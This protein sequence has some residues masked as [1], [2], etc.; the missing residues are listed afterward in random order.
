MFDQHNPVTK[1]KT[2]KIF[3]CFRRFLNIILEIILLIAFTFIVFMLF[4]F[5]AK[6][7]WLIF[8]S[9]PIGQ[10]YMVIF[11]ESCRTTNDVLNR[12]NIGLA[13]NLTLT[14]CAICLILGAILKFLHIT[15]YLY[16]GRGFLGR[17][18][19]FG[20]PAVYIVAVYLQYRGDFTR[21]DTAFTVAI[22]PALC[23][24]ARCFKYTE[25]FVPEIADII[26]RFQK[27]TD[28][29]DYTEQKE[30][31]L[32]GT[33][34]LRQKA[35]T[36]QSVNESVYRPLKLKDIWEDYRVYIIAIPIIIVITTIL[37]AIS[38]KLIFNKVDY[39]SAKEAPQIESPV[40]RPEASAPPAEL[41]GSAQD[42][43]GKALVLIDSTDRNDILK[44]IEYLN[45]AIRQK[46]DYVDAYRQRGAFYAKLDQYS[47]AIDDYDEVIRLKPRDGNLY[48]MRGNAYFALGKISLA[49]SDAKKA[50][51]LGN[52]KLFKIAKGDGDCL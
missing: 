24:F 17:T 40:V 3:S 45:E 27:Q 12:D 34:E 26:H 41:T 20:L 10:T 42:W 25:E 33:V 28:A 31:L 47:L 52:C 13:M 5:S 43:Y 2:A 22:V 8:T 36:K 16:S 15:R 29:F 30:D 9:T 35:D 7:L 6:Y 1:I 18:I 37:S 51:T 44:A 4:L 23:V 11:E 38:Q 14:S 49:C 32:R 21:I 19:F 39:A 48:S 46:P 50:C